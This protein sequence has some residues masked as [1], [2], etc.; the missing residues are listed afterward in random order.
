MK[1]PL[2]LFTAFNQLKS[3]HQ[4]D[5]RLAGRETSVGRYEPRLPYFTHCC[6]SLG[7]GVERNVTNL[8]SRHSN[9][10]VQALQ[11]FLIGVACGAAY[12][13]KH[14][15]DREIVPKLKQGYV[16]VHLN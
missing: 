9:G 2:A 13:V 3:M 5:A 10:I 8:S 7:I 6:N 11:R 15:M 14:H 4:I 1:R 16:A 12:C